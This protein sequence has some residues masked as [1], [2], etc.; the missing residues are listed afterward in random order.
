MFMVT[1]LVFFLS[2]EWMPL[3]PP[4]FRPRYFAPAPSSDA[5]RGSSSSR[6]YDWQWELLRREHLTAN[7]LCFHCEDYATVV[8]HR[9]PIAVDPTRRLDR[10]NLRSCCTECHNSITTNYRLTGV[11]ELPEKK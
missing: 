11:N 3:K 5:V 2:G 4:T 10:T 8:D 7:P 9:V 6:G 1:R